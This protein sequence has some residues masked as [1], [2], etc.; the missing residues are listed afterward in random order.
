M[1]ILLSKSKIKYKFLLVLIVLFSAVRASEPAFKAISWDTI[2]YTNIHVQDYSTEFPAVILKDR[3]IYEYEY[4]GR[5]PYLYKTIH[6]KVL[7]LNDRGVEHFNRVYIPTN[8]VVNIENVRIRSISPNGETVILDETNLKEVENLDNKGSYKIFAIEGVHV[9]S[10][11]EML[12][13]L[14]KY[15]NTNGRYVF[16]DKYPVISAQFEL[17]AP[18]NL[19]FDVKPY[20]SKATVVDSMA[21]GKLYQS[22]RFDTIAALRKEKYSAWK[23]N[24]V[25]VDFSM[26]KNTSSENQSDKTWNRLARSL[27]EQYCT[28]S[29]KDLALCKRMYKRLQIKKLP[30]TV[31][32]KEIENYIKNS[33]EQKNIYGIEE[34]EN[35][36]FILQYGF[37]N[38]VGMVKLYA[39]FFEVADIPYK[40]GFTSD[41]SDLKFDSRFPSYQFLNEPL[42]YFTDIDK[43]LMPT[44]QHVRLGDML[45]AYSDNH[46]MF[47]NQISVG[48]HKTILS[49]ITFIDGNRMVDNYT[50]QQFSITFDSVMNSAFVDYTYKIRGY[51]ARY[52]RP[53]YDLVD[54]ETRD[55]AIANVLDLMGDDTEL[56]DYEVLNSDH[57]IASVEEEFTIDSRL[58]VYSLLQQADKEYLFNI[59]SVI[60]P[61]VEMYDEHQRVNDVELQHRHYY[62]RD[63][64][65]SIPQGYIVDGL[66]ALNIDKVFSVDG[67][68][69]MGFTSSY[70]QT[71][72][73]VTVHIY[74]YYDFIHLNK[75]YYEQFRTVINAAADFNKIAILIKEE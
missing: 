40:L 59:G 16:Q 32:I 37:T 5:N 26:I 4:E 8:N 13:T 23:A 70:T 6:K 60:G 28:F 69:I 68:E 10:V 20:N 29:K 15:A 52:I 17:Y 7:L 18:Q 31:Q 50:K 75:S 44:K 35:I 53:Y 25:R 57:D 34:V 9:G 61:Q 73:T 43:Y 65:I 30:K 45:P 42:F 63:I 74:E 54:Q 39:A 33:I 3:V 46:S 62:D 55:K 38:D 22:I 41:R 24:L 71:D 19:L 56:V 11:I 1:D 36:S 66:D 64:S 27:H 72:S 47:I 14:K 67:K 12:Y 2:L 48:K 58:R 51:E 49:E 21:D